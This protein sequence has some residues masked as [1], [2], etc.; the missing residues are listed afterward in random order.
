[1]KIKKIFVSCASGESREG[2]ENTKIPR[3]PDQCKIYKNV[4]F[5]GKERRRGLK[6]EN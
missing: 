2:F 5:Q 3:I 1:M 6:T 4:H